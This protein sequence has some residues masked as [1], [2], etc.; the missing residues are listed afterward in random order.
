MNYDDVVDSFVRIKKIGGFCIDF[1]HFKA[2]EEKW[3]KEFEYILKRRKKSWLFGCN[4]LNGY[5]YEENTDLHTVRSLKSFNY[6]KT[7]P[8]FLFGQAIGIETNNSITEQLKFKKYLVKMLN[9][10]FL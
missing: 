7:L 3:S 8:E 5:S 10:L 4:H 6:L 9:K 1:S 2:A